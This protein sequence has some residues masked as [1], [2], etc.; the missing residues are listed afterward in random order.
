MPRSSSSRVQKLF[1][2]WFRPDTSTMEVNKC[3]VDSRKCEIFICHSPSLEVQNGIAKDLLLH[4]QKLNIS[5]LCSRNCSIPNE[6]VINEATVCIVILTRDF[7]NCT[8]CL[9]ELRLMHQ[10][11]IHM[12]PIFYDVRPSEVRRTEKGVFRLAFEGAEKSMQKEEWKFF[13]QKTG[14]LSGWK[15]S[16]FRWNSRKLLKAVVQ[17]AIKMV[18]ANVLEVAKH[19]VGLAE[20]TEKLQRLLEVGHEGRGARVLGL[21]GMGGIGKTTLA[22]E[23]FNI[24]R[25]QFKA[26]CF[27]DDIKD[28]VVRAGLEK[29]QGFLLKDLLQIDNQIHSINQGKFL[30]RKCL[31]R[32]EVI[33]VLDNIDDFDQLDALQ[34]PE[35][36]HC[37]SIVLITTRDRRLVECIPNVL[38]Y[39]MDGLEKHYAKELFCWHAFLMPQPALGFDVLVDKFVTYCNGL[40]LSLETL[41]AQVFGETIH[42]WERILQTIV[43][44][45]PGDIDRHLRVSYDALDWS[46]KQIFLDIASFFIGED[47]D[48]A[49][50]VWDALKWFGSAGVRSLQHKCLVKLEKNKFRMHDQLRDMAAKILEEENFNNPGCRS[51]LWRPNDVIKVLDEGSGSETV[52]GLTLVVNAVEDD[53]IHS[54]VVPKS[55]VIRKKGGHLPWS[56][57]S[58]APMTELQLLILE[59]ACIEGDFSFLSR[60]LLCFLGLPVTNLHVL[61]MSGGKFSHLWS[62]IQEIPVQLQELNLRGCLYLQGFPKSIKLLTRLEKLVLSHCLSLVAISDEFC[63]IQALKYLDLSGC[64]NM[65]ALPDNIGNLRNLQY[66]DLS[67][68]ERLEYL[69][70]TIGD[71]LKLEHLDLKGCTALLEIPE[72]FKKLTEIRYLD[73]EQCCKLQV[74]KDII[75]GFQNLEF[76]RAL[77]CKTFYF[78]SVISCQRC[79]RKL[80][81]SCS[82]FTEL[83]EYFGELTSL[84]ELRLWNGHG[85]RAF[86]TTLFTKLTQLKKLTIGLFTLLEDLGSSIKHLRKLTLFSILS[87]RIHCLPMERSDLKNME[88]L[89]IHNCRKLMKLPV[90]SLSGLVTLSLSGTPQLKLDPEA[91]PELSA[92]KKLCIDECVITDGFLKFVFEGFPS[93]EELELG[94][95]RLPNM[96]GIGKYPA[97]LQSVSISSCTNIKEFEI[98]GAFKSLRIKDCPGLRKIIASKFSTKLQTLYLGHCKH[99]VDVCSI[100]NLHNLEYLN[101]EGCFDLESIE[102]LEKLNKLTEFHLFLSDKYLVGGTNQEKKKVLMKGT[103][104]LQKFIGNKQPQ[105]THL[106]AEVNLL[107][108]NLDIH[109]YF[110]QIFA[111]SSSEFKFRLPPTRSMMGTVM[112]CFICQHSKSKNI[113]IGPSG[114]MKSVLYRPIDLHLVNGANK[115]QISQYRVYDSGT[116]LHIGIFTEEYMVMEMLAEESEL[117]LSAGSSDL[118]YGAWACLLP[119][120]EKH[121]VGEI[122]SRQINMLKVHKKN[123]KNYVEREEV[124]KKKLKDEVQDL[125]F[126]MDLHNVY[127]L[128]I[129]NFIVQRTYMLCNT[130]IYE[131]FLGPFS[132]LKRHQL[133]FPGIN[134]LPHLNLQLSSSC[135]KL[136]EEPATDKYVINYWVCTP[137]KSTNFKFSKFEFPYEGSY[138]NLLL[139]E[140]L[141][142]PSQAL[143]GTS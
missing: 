76:F 20:K 92:I 123:D 64:E 139:L 81:V 73:F 31:V 25:S 6:E 69:P 70:P 18:N 67:D 79:I 21:V 140:R 91:F 57:S 19:P 66:L 24:M 114:G 96:L 63:D 128:D 116:F 141:L 53:G 119:V 133:F 22:K 121:L 11:K 17:D 41:G 55:K 131:E 35:V 85:V 42:I 83:P 132:W 15:F 61:D 54:F 77:S 118:I 32:A 103:D 38:I 134:K 49:I 87:C 48:M 100:E 65:Q 5:T 75:G 101:F 40:P 93:L 113:L 27:V 68:C 109:P 52:Q 98:V 59:D 129:A 33:I 82:Q 29:V 58:F 89:F 4:L 78:P 23:F 28:R 72:S 111:H 43:E 3:N 1:S 90:G 26:S 60:K 46:E 56:L 12:I 45:I 142:K 8:L 137:E 7:A 105:A 126:D 47:K 125:M 110:Q 51:R 10:S 104:W 108:S 135:L 84:E 143:A 117:V 14:Y 122:I 136:I 94:N 80:W 39:D 34:V 138:A 62:D 115:N 86:P 13:L 44:I 30:L 36:V 120:S 106:S 112:I 97:N 107:T 50:R 127:A 95:L 2:R 124:E 37:T 9:E 102:N 74:E 88:F 16:D 99:L 130:S 71:L